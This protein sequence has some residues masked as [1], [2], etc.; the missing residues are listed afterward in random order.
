MSTIF[1]VTLPDIGEGV[2]EG[3]VIEWLKEVG[4]AVKQDE[5]VVV[6]MTDKATVELPAPHPGIISKHY[7]KPGEHA[8]LGKPIYDIEVA[9]D[10]KQAPKQAKMVE[11]PRLERE[12][13]I[14]VKGVNALPK[15]RRLAEELSVNLADVTPTGKDGRIELEDVRAFSANQ[16]PI[17]SLE[18][19]QEVPLIGIKGLMAKKMAESNR[20]IPHFSFFE[21]ADA[22][23]LIQLRV[24]VAK[25]AAQAEI[26]LTYMPFF[27]R[28]LSLTLKQFP[29]M[30]SS[31][32]KTHLIV[33]KPHNIG[34]AISSPRG[35]IV[36][37]LKNVDQMNIEQI[38]RAYDQLIKNA[39]ENKLEAADMRD[40]T[41]TLSN[42]GVL[43][44]GGRW[45]TPIINPPEVAILGV[46]RIFKAPVIINE[47]VVA[48][49]VLNLSWSFDHRVL[50][51]SMAAQISHFY[52]Q[53]IQNPASLL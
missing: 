27:I 26:H 29:E 49:D 4:S 21:Q 53:L 5:P 23:R 36:P 19:D 30:N 31:F 47:E 51:G 48:R 40:G 18:G 38:I 42:Y 3:E 9:G 10:V 28:A 13:P 1:T 39:K 43:G 32:Q 46:A 2:V 11:E 44:G 37:V 7:Q 16:R 24:N 25:A 34:I 41:I 6:V 50:D 33:H 20:D 45:A 52:A 14:Q 35:L 17:T 15:A 8:R 12:V 22:V